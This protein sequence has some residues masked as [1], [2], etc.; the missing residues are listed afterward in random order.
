MQ[1]LKRLES[2]YL[3]VGWLCLA[4]CGAVLIGLVMF[5][6]SIISERIEARELAEPLGIKAYESCKTFLPDSKGVFL[7]CVSESCSNN[8]DELVEGYCKDTA[9]NIANWID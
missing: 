4:L 5:G 8:I 9:K 6:E 1:T 3:I 2:K 7:S